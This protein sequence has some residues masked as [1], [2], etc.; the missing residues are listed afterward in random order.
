LM[1]LSQRVEFTNEILPICLPPPNVN[2]A[3][4]GI[5][6]TVTGWVVT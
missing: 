3:T 2:Y 4:P 1:K 6:A 5:M